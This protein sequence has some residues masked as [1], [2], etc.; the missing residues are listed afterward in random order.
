MLAGGGEVGVTVGPAIAAA[1]PMELVWAL[2]CEG[3][4]FLRYRSRAP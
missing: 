4:L 3:S 1:V 2:E